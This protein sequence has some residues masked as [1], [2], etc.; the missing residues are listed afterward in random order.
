MKKTYLVPTCKSVNTQLRTRI[1]EGSITTIGDEYTE[2][3]Y[4]S[5]AKSIWDDTC[6]DGFNW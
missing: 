6:G 2:G 5:D 4:D 1:L 3:N